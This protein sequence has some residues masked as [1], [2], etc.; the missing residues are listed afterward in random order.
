MKTNM[1]GKFVKALFFMGFLSC[2]LG[3]YAQRGAVKADPQL[4]VI[5]L[6]DENGAGINA[7]N[8][9]TDK[10][11][12]MQ[13]PVMKDNGSVV[14]PS[15]SCKIK[16][17]LGSKLELDP[18][19]DLNSAGL[20]NYFTWSS[21][22]NSGQVEITGTL[23]ADLPADVT[24]VNVSF[25]IKATVLGR[26]TITANYLVTN[27]NS[28]TI[29]SDENG[30]NNMASLAYKVEKNAAPG[31]TGEATQPFLYPNPVVDVKTVM[32]ETKQ[33]EFKGTYAIT[34][35]DAAGKNIHN[36][37]VKLD[38]VKRFSYQIGNMA[39]GKY[40]MQIRKTGSEKVYILKFE[41]M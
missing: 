19:F 35:S 21:S 27:H 40:L 30:G 38:G 28:A 32:I 2:T 22:S 29:L 3:S 24:Y 39:A 7:D 25:R 13:L 1:N 16:I 36:G 41:K 14:L 5:R 20:G 4:G 26:S 37:S 11:I 12:K 15:G 18:S 31:A 9:E 8:L 17:G 33:G 10:V 34:I 23:S 6:M